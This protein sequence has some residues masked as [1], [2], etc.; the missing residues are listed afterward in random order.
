[1]TVPLSRR[2]LLRFTLSATTLYATA[3]LRVIHTVAP[4]GDAAL[5]STHAAVVAQRRQP[6][7][8]M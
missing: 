1:M 7:R 3:P 6:R 2:S 8:Q 5:P 4:E